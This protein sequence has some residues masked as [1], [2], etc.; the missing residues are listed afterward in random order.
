LPKFFTLIEELLKA[1]DEDQLAIETLEINAYYFQYVDE[2]YCDD[3]IQTTWA[4]AVNKLQN[5]R[6]ISHIKYLPAKA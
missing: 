2:V 4:R 6:I 3:L 1:I 5:F